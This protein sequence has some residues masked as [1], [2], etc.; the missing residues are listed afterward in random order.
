VKGVKTLQKQHRLSYFFRSLPY[1]SRPIRFAIF[2]LA[3]L[4]CGTFMIIGAT[5]TGNRGLT[6]LFAIP[7]AIA[8]WLFT[9]RTACIA[10]VGVFFMQ[11]G[12]NIASTGNFHWPFPM[13]L[14][15]CCAITASIIEAFSIGFLRHT[16]KLADQAREQ[17]QQAKEQIAASYQREQHL[18]VLK[19]QFL[20]NVSHELRTPLT[21]V[22]GYID[23]LREHHDQ[24]A[25][26]LQATFLEHATHGCEELELLVDNILDAMQTEN[27]VITP[28]LEA[29]CIH[30]II[31]DITQ[32]MLD[33]Q[34]PKHVLQ[35]DIPEKLAVW[36]DRQQLRQVIRNLLSNAFKYSP[37]QAPI[38]IQVTS[39][40]AEQQG[41][42]TSSSIHISIQDEGPGIPP[43]EL[44]TLFRKFTRLKR[45]IT[46]AVRG[47]GLGLYI[48]KQ[49][50]E[51]MGGRIWV[52]STGIAGEGCR[53][54]IALPC[55]PY[56][57]V[58]LPA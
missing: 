3:F 4:L 22:R 13:I 23:L 1:L 14:V 19:D 48:S 11:L 16:L 24:L 17:T 55:A 12:L 36:A 45:D 50:I 27:Q 39:D 46:G 34:E 42:E 37:A 15:F 26:E 5:L 8:A 47:M 6:P 9:P 7:V 58:T 21:E 18:N 30:T 52:E 38:A 44:P 40:S 33:W 31:R 35:M 57:M 25:P 49:F 32:N 28:R 2:F 54:C 56:D 43:D 53:F 51:G 20:L 29:L 10:I 41:S